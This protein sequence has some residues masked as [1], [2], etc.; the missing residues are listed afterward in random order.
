VAIDR[1]GRVGAVF[2]AASRSIAH[3]TGMA[4]AL[5][6]PMRILHLGTAVVPRSRPGH[7]VRATALSLLVVP[8]VVDVRLRNQI[9]PDAT[10]SSH[11]RHARTADVGVQRRGAA[12][13]TPLLNGRVTWTFIVR[14]YAASSTSC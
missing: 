3:P 8:G 9:A 11:D 4:L 1:A 2:A 10:R 13:P 5:H 14:H 12:D 7:D 6:P